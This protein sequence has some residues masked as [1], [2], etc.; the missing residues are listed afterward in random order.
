MQWNDRDR[1]C[2]R[3]EDAL[4]QG[5][6]P[7][8]EEVLEPF[9]FSEQPGLLEE[10]LK[11]QCDYS[12]RRGEPVDWDTYRS[13][14]AENEDIVE[15]VEVW[16]EGKAG[17]AASPSASPTVDHHASRRAD[18]PQPTQPSVAGGTV[19]NGRYRLNHAIGA[20]G[21][22]VV[23]HANDLE[24]DRAVAVKMMQ[25]HSSS[26]KHRFTR[27]F[28]M[29]ASVDHPH[30]VDVFEYGESPAGPFFV[31]ELFPGSTAS[32]LVGAPIAVLL[33][34]VHDIA[35]AIDHIHSRRIVHRDIKPGNILFQRD[36]DRVTA[37]LTDFG[38]AKFANT[39]SSVTGEKDFLGTVAYS[40][41]EQFMGT[42]LDYR[43]D[44]Y[45]FGV[46]CYELLTGRH[47]FRRDEDTFQTLMRAHLDEVPRSLRALNAEVP[48]DVDH[49]VLQL[50]SKDAGLRPRSTYP[51]RVAVAATLG[52]ETVTQ[53]QPSVTDTPLAS[54]FVAR[55]GE[56]KTLNRW[57]QTRLQTRG[58]RTT[59][60]S[61]AIAVVMGDAGIGKSTVLSQLARTAVIQG[62]QV[63]QGRSFEGNLSPY[64]PFVQIVRKVAME[65]DKYRR[66]AETTRPVS[67]A[68]ASTT[69][70]A[71]RDDTGRVEQVLEKFTP[72]LLRMS[73]ELRDFLE[74]DAL[75][76]AESADNP[77]YVY[78]ALARFFVELATVHPICL[79]FED[80]HWAD[81]S[82]L[83]LIRHLAWALQ[84][85]DN[86]NGARH[87]QLAIVGT[88]R[89]GD[90]YPQV[91]QYL[92][93][94]PESVQ[95]PL[96][97]FGVETT[98]D[99]LASCLG[100][101][102]THISQQLATEASRY[103]LGNPFFIA[104]SIREWRLTGRLV[105]ADG[106]WTLR[107]TN[108]GP[109]EMPLTV[110]QTLQ[111]SI[112]SLPV[113]LGRVI[114]MAAVI[115]AVIDVDLLKETLPDLSEFELLDAVDELISRQLI[116]ETQRPR[117]VEF[118]HDVL[119]EVSLQ[120]LSASRRGWLHRV[121][122]ETL[123]ARRAAGNAVPDSVLAE[124]YREASEAAKAFPYFLRAAEQALE[125]F[126]FADAR[127]F[128]ENARDLQPVAAERDEQFRLVWMMAKT[129]SGLGE[130]DQALS[131]LHEALD[132]TDEKDDRGHVYMAI[133]EAR[134]R[135]GQYDEATQAFREGFAEF[136]EWVPRSTP[137][138]LWR[139]ATSA[140]A[141]HCVPR[142]LIACS[143]AREKR[144]QT[145]LRYYPTFLQML[146][147]TDILYFAL[148][149]TRS[150]NLAR[151]TRSPALQSARTI[152]IGFY[153][154]VLA[155]SG[156]T[157]VGRRALRLV[158][159]KIEQQRTAIDE[160]AQNYHA[161]IFLYCTGELSRAEARFST[162][163]D[164]F[165]RINDWRY[166]MAVHFLRHVASARGDARQIELYAREE[167]A[168]AHRTNDEITIA[169]GAYGL[170]DGLA[171]QGKIEEATAFAKQAVEMLDRINGVFR[172][173]AYEELGRVY[174][175]AGN[176]EAAITAL[177][178][179]VGL[180]LRARLFEI[181]SPSLPLL[182][183]ALLGSDWHRR[184]ERLRG[185][186][187]RRAARIAWLA[188]MAG[189]IFPNTLPH[190]LRVSGRLA[191]ARGKTA[192]AE[193]YFQEAIRAAR[194][195]GAEYE[196][197]RTLMDQSRLP[198][199]DAQQH[200]E[201]GSQLLDQLGCVLP[202]DAPPKR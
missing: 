148:G 156:A 197:A 102:R 191:M 96:Q 113:E 138:K 88:T 142:F 153:A 183:E 27:E 149:S 93:S 99:V 117:T 62:A 159:E 25:Q 188:R 122:A 162:A 135:K 158:D 1:A 111:Q 186:R 154:S 166:A 165:H 24:R 114:S 81:Q 200:W 146:A 131:L 12:R 60:N 71:S 196:E 141:F 70:L 110:R 105:R 31:M 180:V 100:T 112:E 64:E 121:V 43:T 101:D 174:L 65:Q 150:A 202:S 84:A 194:A 139:I 126:S 193:Q 89:T 176:F 155:L 82:S 190:A 94:L 91:K 72:E 129:W 13:R 42:E 53:Q 106:C 195:V 107:D 199:D 47:P 78:R 22:A 36:G 85:D 104:Q 157:W 163:R 167:L 168:V 73:P 48:V 92:S 11:L 173:I 39:S 189:W 18:S 79:M 177:Q 119:R 128:L 143:A 182:V 103:C 20:G 7:S 86:D 87:A 170:A 120:A 49:A 201:R 134:W 23:W 2:D 152:C 46:V 37:K 30:C 75:Q 67:A 21:M 175:L 61:S 192:R 5:L 19:L 26:G 127:M 181:S 140:F 108:D 198:G 115:G 171:R 28:S 59:A 137:G 145:I 97:P 66:R 38:L 32:E 41:P 185:A 16:D 51:L 52:M 161:S 160:A 68:I 116:R 57:I 29:V 15:R 118:T 44:L 83:S 9:A 63:Y 90:D 50:L 33:G 124:H 4:R 172:C 69:L 98:Q 130:V 164:Q 169:Y 132:L 3:F 178:Q 45:S 76:L 10:L 58:D 151:S 133:A 14:F 184:G 55:E 125:G 147:S 17:E 136:G 34:V 95:V 40:S 109:A 77:D 123:E 56:M 54:A 74:G 179:A 187:R 8:I 6:R 144:L 80:L 35:E